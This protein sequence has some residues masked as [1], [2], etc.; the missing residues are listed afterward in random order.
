MDI[1]LGDKGP[2]HFQLSLSSH[3]N[4]PISLMAH[5]PT[6]EIAEPSFAALVAAMQQLTL[7]LNGMMFHVSLILCLPTN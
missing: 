4:L 7:A 5:A 1:N 3:L 2:L 6:A